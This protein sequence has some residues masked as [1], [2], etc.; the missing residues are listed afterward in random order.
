MIAFPTLL[1]FAFAL[2]ENLNAATVTFLVNSPLERTFPG[3]TA[4]SPSLTCFS[5]LEMFTSLR[6]RV[7]FLMLSAKA[8]QS[9]VFSLFASFLKSIRRLLALRF[10][11]PVG[12]A[13]KNLDFQFLYKS[14]YDVENMRERK[15]DGF[16]ERAISNYI[17]DFF[18]KRVEEGGLE[19]YFQ[20]DFQKWNN[21]WPN[22]EYWVRVNVGEVYYLDMKRSD[23]ARQ[24]SVCV[25]ENVRNPYHWIERLK[26]ID[27]HCFSYM[28]DFE[29]PES[30]IISGLKVWYKEI[31]FL[32]VSQV[33]ALRERP[34]AF[35]TRFWSFEKKNFEQATP[36]LKDFYAYL[37][38]SSFDLV[39][40]VEKAPKGALS[41][42]KPVSS[43][44]LSEVDQGQLSLK[45]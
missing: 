36:L 45:E 12:F 34:D 18:K 43:G 25:L 14:F 28:V 23:R 16:V 35:P 41:L 2:S 30:N 37:L 27:S 24:E 40:P 31:D 42:V 7:G 20:G 29:I 22:R 32:G 3:I 8:F 38:A 44:G 13:I 5:M 11:G 6:D 9:C 26:E 19:T 1:I 21:F 15:V 33:E 10:V 17:V 4:V 39:N